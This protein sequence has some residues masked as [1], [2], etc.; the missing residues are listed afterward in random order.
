MTLALVTASELASALG[1]GER[2]LSGVRADVRRQVVTAAEASH[3]DAALEGL[4]A[5]VHTHVARQF[6]RAGEAALAANGRAGVRTL[7]RWRLA[8]PACGVLPGPTGLGERVGRALRLGLDL[9]REGFDG[10]Q[11]R[12]L[13]VQGGRQHR[14]LVLVQTQIALL[15]RQEVVWQHLHSE[16]GRLNPGDRVGGRGAMWKEVLGCRLRVS[17]GEEVGA[18]GRGI[19][20]RGGKDRSHI[21]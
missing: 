7:V 21:R 10:G 11:R 8:L 20:R 18:N 14:L 13:R 5:C 12:E 19:R 17:G 2:L 9:C 3:A 6:I 15:L 1:A 16:G 4:L